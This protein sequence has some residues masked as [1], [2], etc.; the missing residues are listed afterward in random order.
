MAPVDLP[1]ARR[2]ADTV[3]DPLRKAYAYGVMAESLVQ[4]QPHSA[5]ELL[6]AAFAILQTAVET[7][8]DRYTGHHSAASVAGC[9]LPVAEQLDPRLVPEFFWQAVSFRLPR[10]DD[11]DQVW[12]ADLSDAFLSLTLARYDRAVP[13]VLLEQ[14]AKSVESLRRQH[15]LLNSAL[16][17]AATLLDPPSAVLLLEELA[18]WKDRERMTYTIT[19]ALTQ[20]GDARWHAVQKELT[21]WVED[22]E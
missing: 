7:G 22:R 2:V 19:R 20:D 1:R 21:L 13:R 15:G 3:G 11:E 4:A 17:R 14:A 12:Q 5:E 16:F 18:N 9:L 6:R 8:K 10:P